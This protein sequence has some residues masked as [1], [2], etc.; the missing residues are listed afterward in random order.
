MGLPRGHRDRLCLA[1]G[2]LEVQ[3][4]VMTDEMYDDSTIQ[5][6]IEAAFGL[7]LKINEV[8][9]RRV[10]TGYTSTATL[11]LS[12]PNALYVFV[13][14]QSNMVLADVRSI[15][16]SMNVDVEE[17]VPPHGDRDYF[18]RIGEQKFK[19]IFPGKH[20]TSPEDTRY[21]QT[22]APYSPALAKIARVKGEIRGFHFESKSWRKVRGY[23]YNKITL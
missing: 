20:I 8:A 21:Y 15:L 11:F 4:E 17:F 12:P 22:L 14:S 3:L 10:P 6:A 1:V 2:L 18:K 23:T 9:A 16:R 13:Q 7:K 5:Q 19:E